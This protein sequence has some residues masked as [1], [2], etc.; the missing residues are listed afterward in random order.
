[1]VP[2]FM[3]VHCV[4]AFKTRFGSLIRDFA[5]GYVCVFLTHLKNT[6]NYV[7]C[8]WRKETSCFKM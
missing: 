1:M 6:S 5:F 3:G 7:K 4:G 2:F 8:S